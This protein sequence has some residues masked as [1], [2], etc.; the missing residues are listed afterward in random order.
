MSEGDVVVPSAGSKMPSP[1]RLGGHASARSPGR[2]HGHRHHRPGRS[3]AEAALVASSA[4][5]AVCT[6]V[7]RRG[8]RPWLRRGAPRSMRS[9]PRA[10][11]KQEQWRA[12]GWT[13]L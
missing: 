13:M 4:A 1:A 9:T 5:L 11:R 2:G 12:M 3:S 8:R 10:E 6:F 7:S